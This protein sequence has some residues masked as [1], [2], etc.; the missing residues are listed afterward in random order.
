M[1]TGAK[2]SSFV[3]EPFDNTAPSESTAN[4]HGPRR[5]KKGDGWDDSGFILGPDINPGQESPVGEPWVLAL[6]ALLFAGVMAWK[7]K[8]K[9]SL[10]G[11]S[12]E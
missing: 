2:Y 1:T 6:F 9:S 3:Y 5:A 7:K 4:G 12:R 11:A 8:S 10:E